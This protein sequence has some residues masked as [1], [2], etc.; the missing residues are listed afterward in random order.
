MTAAKEIADALRKLANEVGE[1]G[2]ALSDAGLHDR[3]LYLAA[4]HIRAQAERLANSL[5]H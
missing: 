2:A 5:A 3:E 1:I 4:A